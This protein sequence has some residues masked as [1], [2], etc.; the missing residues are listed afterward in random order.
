MTLKHKAILA[1]FAC[2]M[3][4]S[5]M[6]MFSVQ[7][8]VA[9]AFFQLALLAGYGLSHLFS[10]T[11]VRLHAALLLAFCVAAAFALPID[12]SA[13]WHQTAMR[14]SAGNVMLALCFSTA[15]P[16][17]TLS[18]VTSTLQRMFAATGHVDAEDPYFLYGASNL[19]S[20]VGLL[21][22]PFFVE[23]ALALDTQAHEWQ[24]IFTV[25]GAM[26]LACVAILLLR[27]GDAPEAAAT[28][29]E[30]KTTD[31]APTWATRANWLGIAFVTTS[32]SAPIS[33][34]C[35][36]FGCCRWGFSCSA[37]CW[38]LPAG[39]FTSCARYRR[40]RCCWSG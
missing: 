32:L 36:C 3:F 34:P 30:C 17:V 16:F 21:S 29:D 37:T 27:R 15:L 39:V 40:C 25:L 2:S 9:M 5:A 31:T 38:P 24:Q 20:F 7:P 22:Y 11:P 8:I 35:R 10:F 4:V 28:K 12:F 19:G 1:A 14:I 23:P 18:L 13:A 33:A 26:I 6:L